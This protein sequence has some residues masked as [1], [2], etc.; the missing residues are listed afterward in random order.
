ML[1]RVFN[2]GAA[3]RA[4]A[5]PGFMAPRRTYVTDAPEPEAP[6]SAMAVDKM[7]GLWNE[8]NL[9]SLTPP[10]LTAFLKEQ[11]VEID[12]KWK[13]AA[14]V[15]QV[16]ELLQANEQKAKKA[17]QGDQPAAGGGGEGYGSWDKDAATKGDMLLDLN[18]AGFYQ[19]DT[20]AAPRAFQL[21]VDN[22]ATDLVV[23][24]VNTTSFPGAAANA[25]SYTLTAADATAASRARFVKTLKWGAINL[26]T[27][28]LDGQLHADIGK[29]VLKTDAMRK[30]QRVV[31]SWTLQ[32]RLQ[33]TA[34]YHWVSCAASTSK[35]AVETFLSENGFELMQKPKVSFD[36]TVRRA[37]DSLSIVLNSKG[38]TMSVNRQWEKLQSSHFVAADGPDVRFI[39]RA[40]KPVSPADNDTFTKVPIV[41]VVSENIEIKLPPEHG[42]VLY[43]SENEVRQWTRPLSTGGTLTVSETS[44]QPLIIARDE[45]DGER[46]EYALDVEVPREGTGIGEVALEVH[47]IAKQLA[48]VARDGF[49][50]QFQTEAKAPDLD[51]E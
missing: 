30:G 4:L 6:P 38:A 40:R 32:Q 34:P 13:K 28:Q 14:L 12:P 1:R 27:L 48:Q 45:E 39:F 51:T 43:C 3:A 37:N 25:E 35:D 15:R 11:K 33:A 20:Q 17:K 21:L 8:G 24:R 29:L 5:A 9:F 49:N 31:S 19:G 47:G 26:R 46:L 7:W 16:E 22:T 50:Q 10:Q 2:S 23:A 41:D 36:V 18:Q 42:E 44:R